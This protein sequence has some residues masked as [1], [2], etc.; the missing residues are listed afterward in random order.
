ML[1][2]KRSAGIAP[3]VNLWEYVTCMPAPKVIKAA[4]FG[5]EAQRCHLKFKTGVSAPTLL[6]HCLT[7]WDQAD[8]PPTELYK[9][10]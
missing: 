8:A 5:F 3:D 10:G 1:A 2:I 7:V 9:L 4:H 6:Y